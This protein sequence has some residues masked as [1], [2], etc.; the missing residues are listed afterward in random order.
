[1]LFFAPQLVG[2]ASWEFRL[3]N[4]HEAAPWKRPCRRYT[5]PKEPAPMARLD[6][7]DS[8]LFLMEYSESMDNNG[9]A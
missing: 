9:A 4:G 5:L 6:P 1:M 2:R 3:F 8:A 7:L